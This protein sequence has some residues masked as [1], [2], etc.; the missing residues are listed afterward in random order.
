[1]LEMLG[2]F[3]R[4]LLTLDGGGDS[5]LHGSSG[6]LRF[7]S[8][9]TSQFLLQHLSMLLN[10]VLAWNVKGHKR[11]SISIRMRW[12]IRFLRSKLTL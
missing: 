4:F 9:S 10:W 3:E 2:S 5:S 1:M 11:S 12:F 7:D 8:F 6:L